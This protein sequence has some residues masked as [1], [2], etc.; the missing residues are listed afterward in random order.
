MNS[1]VI[2]RFKKLALSVFFSGAVFCLSPVMPASVVHAEACTHENYDWVTLVR[3]TCSK[4]GKEVKICQD[5]EEIIETEEI[6][7]TEH[8]GNWEKTKDP[9]CILSGTKSY[10]CKVCGTEIEKKEIPAKGHKFKR[11]GTQKATCQSPKIIEKECSVCGFATTEQSGGAVGHSYKWKVTRTATC[12]REGIKTG[13]CKMCGGTKTEIIPCSEKHKYG[14]WS[15]KNVAVNGKKIDVTEFRMCKVCRKDCKV[16]TGTTTAFSKNHNTRNYYYKF[17]KGSG[18]IVILCT[19]CH[20]SVT[21]KISGGKIQ[22]TRPKNDNSKHTSKG[23][24]MLGK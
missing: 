1:K 21:G 3:P 16:L 10:L 22:F 4:P 23:W 13:T 19:V 11:T 2:T 18:R 20:K 12:A 17:T 15:I 7:K 9:T 5:C 14:N 6:E 8:K 24:R